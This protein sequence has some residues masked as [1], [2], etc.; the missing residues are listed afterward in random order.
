[1]RWGGEKEPSFPGVFTSPFMGPRPTLAGGTG[2]FFL[3]SDI[4]Q[5]ISCLHLPVAGTVLGQ[6]TEKQEEEKDTQCL[7]SAPRLFNVTL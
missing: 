1:M 7:L 3:R 2:S 5:A 4:G 6:H